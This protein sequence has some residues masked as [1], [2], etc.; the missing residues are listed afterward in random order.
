V[1]RP[2][3][4]TTSRYDVSRKM[5]SE[6]LDGEPKYRVDQVWSGLYKD[7]RDPEGIT[8][9]SKTLRATIEELLP[10]ALVLVRESVSRDRGTRKF[11]WQLHDGHLIETVLMHYRK[12]TTVC[13]S[14][15]AGCAMGCGFCATGQAGFDRH[16][17]VGEIVEQVIRA[18]QNSAPRRVDNVVFMGMGEPLANVDAVFGAINRLHDDVGIGARHMTV[19]T[20][21]VVPGIRKFAKLD[22]QVGLAVSLHAANNT[23]R[24]KLV[25]INKTYPLDE[26]ARACHDYMRASNRRISLEWAMMQG[27]NDGPR[28]A[29][30]LASYAIPLRAHVNL[31]PLNPT[32]GWPTVGSSPSTIEAFKSDLETR[33]VNV[34]VRQNRGTD[35]DAACGQLKADQLIEA[36]KRRR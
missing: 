9:I 34:T 23:K 28:D 15:Q 33:G 24:N 5:F 12:R 13:V 8:N 16:L 2:T 7:L 1:Y 26:L 17:T 21:G 31:I 29:E 10:R 35:I 3:V 25:P 20:V 4:A 6:L 18:A 19:S 22:M 11:L 30:E 32:P 27:T 14:S 36:P